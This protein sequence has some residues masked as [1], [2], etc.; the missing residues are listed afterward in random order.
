MKNH[1]MINYSFS[2][3]SDFFSVSTFASAMSN[4]ILIG[5]ILKTF[6]ISIPKF[7]KFICPS[8]VECNIV[9]NAIRLI[10]N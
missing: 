7:Y 1:I 8:Y 5:Y 3:A 2:P 10:C 6:L 9:S 4:A